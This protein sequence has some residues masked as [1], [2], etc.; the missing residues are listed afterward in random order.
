MASKV[1]AVMGCNGLCLVLFLIIFEPLGIFAFFHND[2]DNLSWS[3]CRIN[4][5]LHWLSRIVDIDFSV[6]AEIVSDG[7]CLKL[8][9]LIFVPLKTF[10][11]YHIS[12]KPLPIPSFRVTKLFNWLS[13][14]EDIDDEV[15]TRLLP[16]L[17]FLVFLLFYFLST[18]LVSKFL[19][20]KFSTWNTLWFDY[21]I[22]VFGS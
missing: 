15:I 5:Y 16:H 14:S 22:V 9:F 3:F 11:F 20:Y 18:Q 13:I 12:R 2:R 19:L 1:M 8:F 17:C 7:L 21:L 10:V 6:I 4:E